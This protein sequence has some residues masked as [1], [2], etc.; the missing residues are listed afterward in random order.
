M[1]KFL[2]MESLPDGLPAAEFVFRNQEPI[3]QRLAEWLPEEACVL[4]IASGWGQHMVYWSH[5]LPEL[6]ITNFTWQPTEVG[7]RMLDLH[8]WYE[9]ANKT[10]VRAPIEL[11]V[12]YSSWEFT[13]FNCVIANNFSHYVSSSTVEHLFRG[14]GELLTENGR[15]MLYGPVNIGGQYTSDSNREFDVWLRE[16]VDGAHIKADSFLIE[17]ANQCGFHLLA[18]QDMPANNVWMVFEKVNHDQ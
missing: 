4:E 13:G 5:R 18:I 1:T 7:A 17:L 8:Q 10:S 6:G 9:Y 12:E 16:N 3:A 2:T 11:D 15:L 14:A